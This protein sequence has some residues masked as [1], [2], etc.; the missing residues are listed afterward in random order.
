MKSVRSLVLLLA[1]ALPFLVHAQVP[2]QANSN[3]EQLLASKDPR[4]AANKR[5]VYDFWRE[6]FEAGHMELAEKYMAEPYI[7]HN[8]NVPTGRAAFVEFFSKFE[9]PKPIDAHVKA[10]L[11]AVVAEGNLVVLS[12]AREVAD[13]KDATKRYTTT[14]FD[15]FRIEDGK[16]AEHWDAAQRH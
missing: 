8:P 16:I 4:A 7:Q 6:V 15:M 12:F 11:V 3:H 2:V 10:P 13:P 5:L 9:K 14:W 1:L